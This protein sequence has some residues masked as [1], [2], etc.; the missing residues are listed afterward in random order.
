MM[1]TLQ[2]IA[3]VLRAHRDE[4]AARYG[5]RRIAVFGSFARREEA[6]PSD[7]DILVEL[8]R[9]IGFRFFEFWDELEA[10]LGRKVDLATAGALKQKPR[11][12]ES[13]KEDLVYV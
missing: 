12:W 5:V 8:E 4:L 11:L 6:P 9:P 7:V 1:K 2:D 13:I 3:A 10:I